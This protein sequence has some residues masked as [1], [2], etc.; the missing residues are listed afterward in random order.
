MAVP[1]LLLAGVACAPLPPTV[2]AARCASSSSYLPPQIAN[3]PLVG[4][5][6]AGGP[7]QQI[8]AP[9]AALLD[10]LLDVP[11]DF[12]VIP[13][14]VVTV[15]IRGTDAAARA[16]AAA[17]RR[18]LGSAV[19]IEIGLKR[20]AGGPGGGPTCLLAP[21]NWAVGAAPPAG[22]ATRVMPRAG[23]FGPGVAVEAEV[24]I[25]NRRRQSIRV[26]PVTGK[27]PHP[28][29]GVPLGQPLTAPGS[30]LAVNASVGLPAR[31]DKAAAHLLEGSQYVPSTPTA[32]GERTWIPVTCTMELRGYAAMTIP[33]GGSATLVVAASPLSLTPGDD[34]TLPGGE[35]DLRALVVIDTTARL[36]VLSPDLNTTVPVGWRTVAVPA[37]RVR[38]G[39]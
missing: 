3:A 8:P 22:V 17:V 19:D 6:T 1:A 27:L 12:G 34:P 23:S 29:C 4:F 13:A 33:P 20:L 28:A 15:Q 16:T 36:S 24:T 18:E 14:P 7:W 39:S 5:P 31:A 38:I 32:G 21:P 9:N 25:T 11:G 2:A 26:A 37:V 10:R 30:L 35:Y